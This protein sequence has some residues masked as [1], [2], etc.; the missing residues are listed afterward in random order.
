MQIEIEKS[1]NKI[2]FLTSTPYEKY[3]LSNQVKK[4]DRVLIRHGDLI[5]TNYQIMNYRKRGL[6]RAFLDDKN[7]ILSFMNSHYVIPLSERTILVHNEHGMI[8][9]PEKFE[10]LNFYTINNVVD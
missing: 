2:D 9:I 8:I 10:R 7:G 1:L 6:R 3:D 5:V 4:G